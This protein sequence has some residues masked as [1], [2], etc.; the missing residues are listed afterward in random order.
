MFSLHAHDHL[1][2]SQS[3]IVLLCLP[4]MVR[5]VQQEMASNGHHGPSPSPS[6]RPGR[7]QKQSSGSYDARGGLISRSEYLEWG[8]FRCNETFLR[9]W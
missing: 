6:P 8:H 2:M 5:F 4:G 1:I 7:D 3:C 9:S